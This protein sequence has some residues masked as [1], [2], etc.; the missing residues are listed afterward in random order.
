MKSFFVYLLSS[1][2][3]GTLY[4]GVTSNLQKRI[5]QHKEKLV[6]GFSKRYNVDRLVWYEEHHSA[7]SA[8]KREKQIKTWQRA[9]KIQLIEEMNPNW[10][11]LYKT[12]F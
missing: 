11:D 12:L 8:I 4:I 3:N 2:Y 5:Y 10:F 1:Q 7:E 9:W 6:D